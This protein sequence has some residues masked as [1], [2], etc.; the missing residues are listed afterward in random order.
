MKQKKERYL[1]SLITGTFSQH[2]RKRIND[3]IDEF[4]L[5]EKQLETDIYRQTFQ[6]AER[7]EQL[8]TMEPFKEAI[9]KFKLNHESMSET[10]LKQWLNTNVQRILLNQDIVKMDFKCLPFRLE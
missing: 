9:L 2:E 3:K 6:K 1:D 5:L 7:H 4:S 10:E 8:L